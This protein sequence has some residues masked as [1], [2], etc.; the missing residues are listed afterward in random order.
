MKEEIATTMRLLGVKNLD[1]L[2]PE[3]IRYLD[4]EPAGWA[5]WRG[6]TRPG[7]KTLQE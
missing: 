2:K 1:E 7:D 4:R 6:G 3:M 5:G